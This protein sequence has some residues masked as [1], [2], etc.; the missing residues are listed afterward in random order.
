MESTEMMGIK[1]RNLHVGGQNSDKDSRFKLAGLSSP[2]SHPNAHLWTWNPCLA[3][4]CLFE[5]RFEGSP[6]VF[7]RHL[8]ALQKCKDFHTIHTPPHFP[9]ID[10][11]LGFCASRTFYLF[12]RSA[13]WIR[14]DT[15]WSFIFTLTVVTKLR[16]KKPTNPG[17]STPLSPLRTQYSYQMPQK[18]SR[19][20][21]R[22]E[23]HDHVTEPKRPLWF[24]SQA[25]YQWLRVP[26]HLGC[27]NG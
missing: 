21:K 15:C 13:G 14:R 6:L 22:H 1:K 3:M 25:S 9:L 23:H 7:L 4:P 12:R 16:E 17:I 11:G 26:S 27:H 8:L 20:Q 18:P 19:L 10:Q 5:L 24:S 2:L